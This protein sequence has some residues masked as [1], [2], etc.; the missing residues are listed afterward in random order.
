MSER[1]HVSRKL[2]YRAQLI[3]YVLIVGIGIF[4]F[5]QAEKTQREIC[6]STENNRAVTAELVQSINALGTNLIT[7]GRDFED[8]TEQQQRALDTLDKFE[9]NRLGALG[10]ELDCDE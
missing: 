4:G 8:L 10:P 3:A 9:R 6:L 2:I 1:T 5:W 7:D